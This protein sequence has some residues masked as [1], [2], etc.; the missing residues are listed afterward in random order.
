MKVTVKLDC[1]PEEARKMMGLP[2][3]GKLNQVYVKELSKF[4]QGSGSVE[5]LQNFTKVITPMGEA[6]I[7]LFS[8][9]IG[10]ALGSVSGDA[11]SDSSKSKSK[12][13]KKKP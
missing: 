6:G 1:T 3:V 2:D 5:Q 12:P 7:K 11:D 9:L 8:S 10:G 13:A 4:V